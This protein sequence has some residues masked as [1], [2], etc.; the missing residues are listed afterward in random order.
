M[1]QFRMPVK[2]QPTPYAKYKSAVRAFDIGSIVEACGRKSA[3]IERLAMPP[4]ATFPFTQWALMDIARVAIAYGRPSGKTIADHDLAQLC[5]FHLNIDDPI[6][7]GDSAGVAGALLRMSHEQFLGQVD[8]LP[9]FARTLLLF[10][11]DASWPVG[12]SPT[13]MVDDWFEQSFGMDVDTYVAGIF[14]AFTAAASNGG[15]FDLD[16]LQGDAFERIRA[17]FSNERVR[18][19]F[20]RHLSVDIASF[21]QLNRDAERRTRAD[22]QKHSFNPL[23][24]KPFITDIGVVP[25]APNVRAIVDK[26]SPLSIFYRAIKTFGNSFATD[27]GHVFEAYVGKQLELL[28]GGLVLPEVRYWEGKNRQDSIDWFLQVGEF[29]VLVECKSTRPDEHVR[30]GDAAYLESLE[31]QI[32]KGIAQINRSN[33]HFQVI[34]AAEPRLAGTHQRVGVVVTL[35]DHFAA[36]SPSVRA[37]LT[38]ADIPTVVLSIRELEQFMTLSVNELE[39]LVSQAVGRCGADNVLPLWIGDATGAG[40]NPIIAAAFDAFEVMRLVDGLDSPVGL[41]DT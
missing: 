23:R 13:V 19:V 27:L 40:P 11:T 8:V 15:R 24:D 1:P 7:R 30:L 37:D 16:L 39:G 21:K 36:T 2:A 12:K 41:Q 9:A 25:I 38:A 28:S 17:T 20:D 31:R 18:N 33:A 10:G 14:I 4:S 3:E 26:I 29:L 5:Q 32:G 34:C 6:T 35:E 22:L